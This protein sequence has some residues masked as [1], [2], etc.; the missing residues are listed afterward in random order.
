MD[1]GDFRLG[2]LQQTN[3]FSGLLEEEDQQW[4]HNKSC[5]PLYSFCSRLIKIA[6]FEPKQTVL[7]KT[8]LYI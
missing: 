1:K 5:G 6:F 8:H 7:V 3:L 2:R 4:P